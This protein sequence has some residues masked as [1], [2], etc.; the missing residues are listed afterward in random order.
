MKKLFKIFAVAMAF[1]FAAVMMGWQQADALE[2]I[3][4]S[5]TYTIVYDG[6]TVEENCSGSTALTIINNAGLVNGTDYIVS[7]TTITL[8][9]SGWAKS[10]GG[11]NGNNGGSY[12]VS[13]Y[14]NNNFVAGFTSEAEA[15]AF[16]T[17]NGL[18]EGTDYSWSGSNIIMTAS[19]MSKLGY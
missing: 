6:N 13:V 8:T 18:E 15:N 3:D 16:V 14:Y 19:G 4:E 11:N 2:E 5:V 12:A 10:T 7:G 17:Q 1:G 9:D